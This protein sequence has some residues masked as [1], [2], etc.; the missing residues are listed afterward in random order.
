MRARGLELVKTNK[1]TH[2]LHAEIPFQNFGLPFKKSRFPQKISVWD[3]KMI[4]P[5]SSH[6][7]FPDYCF[8]PHLLL[9][10]RRLATPPL[11]LIFYRPSQRWSRTW[12]DQAMLVTVDHA[13][14]CRPLNG[15]SRNYLTV[16]A[17]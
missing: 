12:S 6:P 1:W 17:V 5:I 16:C 15:H 8:F 3:D 2:I 7:K 10:Y 9:G 4:N 11:N 14:E 13:R